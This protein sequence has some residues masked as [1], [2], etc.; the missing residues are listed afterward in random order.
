MTRRKDDSVAV[1][2]ER[3]EFQRE[4]F[5]GRSAEWD[6]E[7]A[8]YWPGGSDN[9]ETRGRMPWIRVLVF[10]GGLA[11]EQERILREQDAKTEAA[12]QAALE[13]VIDVPQSVELHTL[14]EHGARREVTVY[15]KSDVALR[16]IHARH[17]LLAQLLDDGAVLERDGSPESLELRIRILE[18]QSYQQRVIAWIATTP[19]V[20]LP[21]PERAP[22]PVTPPEIDALMTLDFYVIA[23]AMQRVNVAALAAL[24]PSLTNGSS[25]DWSVFY[26]SIGLETGVAPASLAR[27]RS[28]VGL[29]A[30]AAEASRGRAEAEERA[31]R[32]AGHTRP[33]SI[34]A[35]AG[36][37]NAQTLGVV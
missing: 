27:D 12:K 23:Q 5:L 22:R 15:A 14:D 16:E 30:Q 21:F 37:V 1:L 9:K 13:A 24:K 29:V 34:P 28:L 26:S 19:G 4:Q 2:R 11:R 8:T 35:N 20:G 17:L 10:F 32:E 31:K 7:I 6:A 25:P 18:E 33:I 3:A 36:L